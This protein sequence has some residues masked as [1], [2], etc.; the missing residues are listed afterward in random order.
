[1]RSGAARVGERF[2]FSLAAALTLALT[3]VLM[4]HAAATGDL[5]SLVRAY[6]ANPTPAGRAAVES[7]AAIASR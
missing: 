5:K 1:M 4:L 3:A 2:L 6:R 7:Y